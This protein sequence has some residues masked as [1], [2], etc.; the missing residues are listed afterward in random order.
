MIC[1]VNRLLS[2]S[3][4]FQLRIMNFAEYVYYPIFCFLVSEFFNLERSN[5]SFTLKP[6]SC[7]SRAWVHQTWATI[8]WHVARPDG[9]SSATANLLSP[10]SLSLLRESSIEEVWFGVGISYPSLDLSCVFC[11]CRLRPL[12]SLGDDAQRGLFFKGVRGAAVLI[13]LHYTQ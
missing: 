6:K 4:T 7:L 13:L 3:L 10:R 11:W 5:G 8:I 1:L 2:S 12:A 9:A